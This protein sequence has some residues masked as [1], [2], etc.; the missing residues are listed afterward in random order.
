[1]AGGK[2]MIR[3]LTKLLFAALLAVPIWAPSRAFA[4]E[5]DFTVGSTSVTT[6]SNVTVS[7]FV[8]TSTAADSAEATLNFDS[9]KLSFVSASTSGS[10]YSSQLGSST[11]SSSYQSSQ[12]QLNGSITGS[13]F[14]FSVTFQAISS[15]SA[16]LSISAQRALKSGVTLTSSAGSGTVTISDPAAPPDSGSGGTTTP[17]ADNSSS[18]SSSSGSGASNSSQSTATSTGDTQAPSLTAG[19]TFEPSQSTIAAQFT[20]DEPA[21]A[22]ITW[23]GAGQE[24]TVATSDLSTELSVMLGA[25]QPLVPGNEYAVTISLSDEAGNTTTLD[26]RTVRTIGVTYQ[27]TLTDNEG[28]PLAGQ[29]VTLN[30]TPQTTTT[31]DQGVATFTDVTPGPHTLSFNYNGVRIEQAVEVGIPTNLAEPTN[32]VITLPFAIGGGG[33][34]AESSAPTTA[35]A[36]L[37][38]AVLAGLTAGLLLQENSKSRAFLARTLQ[39][40]RASSGS[41]KQ[42]KE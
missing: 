41:T 28:K 42:S 17:P 11:G 19:P 25:D 1:M 29:E 20:T 16:S 2:R 4:A 40:K 14:L 27:A 26:P 24:G 22:T 13:N 37:I 12:G 6:G 10:P 21:T 3:R 8:N 33:A 38:I 23:S 5:A 18:G 15:G 36:I 30:S 31:N 9:S 34:I 7:V 39:R 32:D 35:T